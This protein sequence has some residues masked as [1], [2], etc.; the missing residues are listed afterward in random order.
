MNRLSP[1]LLAR[2]DAKID[3]TAERHYSLGQAEQGKAPESERARDAAYHRLDALVEQRIARIRNVRGNRA[4]HK[5]SGEMDRAVQS[6]ILSHEKFSNLLK[7]MNS[8]QVTQGVIQFLSQPKYS[9]LERHERYRVLKTIKR[10]LGQDQMEAV[11]FIDSMLHPKKTSRA[12]V[13]TAPAS[14]AFAAAL[15]KLVAARK[16]AREVCAEKTAAE[17]NGAWG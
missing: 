8:S 10:A 12:S 6:L 14:P 1:G 7:G 5:L 16:K 3:A 17:Y 2:L 4:I 13:Q 15:S 9:G 11:A